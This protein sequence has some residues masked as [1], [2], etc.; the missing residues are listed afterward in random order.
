MNSLIVKNL[1]LQYNFGQLALQNINFEVAQGEIL[2]VL[3][4]SDGGKTSLIKG[5]AGLVKVLRGDIILN[6][7]N[8][9]TLPI[10]DR[11]VSVMY[12][13]R[14]LFNNKSV[15][16]NLLYPLKI[17]KTELD[18]AHK[19]VG[20]LLDEFD[21]QKIKDIK[22]SKLSEQDKFKVALARL[23]IRKSDAYLIDDPLFVFKDEER[24][25]IFE[26]FLPYL[27]NLGKIAPVV[28]ATSSIEETKILND[29]VIILNYG[30]QLQAGSLAG[31]VARPNN[32]LSY[33]LFHNNVIV[34]ETR[35][36]QGAKGVYLTIAG[37]EITIDIEKLINPIY[38]DAEVLACYLLE[39][40]DINKNSLYL[41][42]K[43]SEKLIYFN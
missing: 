2:T 19:K 32:V 18:S 35:I 17:R 11:N 24:I 12:E 39:G 29:M 16:F 8:I 40:K 27:K 41:F 43:N 31:I 23:F 28:Y 13:D 30:V 3:A 9:T 34:E 26:Y 20:E 25:K 10:R 1:Y 38:I 15:F 33:K 14:C 36:I 6:G 37:K 4:P 7:K 21:L 5:L 22:I 42:D